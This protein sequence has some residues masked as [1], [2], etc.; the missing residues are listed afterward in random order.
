[1]PGVEQSILTKLLDRYSPELVDTT[2]KWAG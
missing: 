1:M 2:V